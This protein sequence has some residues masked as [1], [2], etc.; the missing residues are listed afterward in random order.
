VADLDLDH[1]T[2]GR[3]DFDAAAYYSRPDIFILLVD[4]HKKSAI[5]V[6]A[7]S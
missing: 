6:F 7:G 3:Y 5:K 2:R 1:V 4:R